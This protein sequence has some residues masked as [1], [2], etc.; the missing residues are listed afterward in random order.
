MKAN[1]YSVQHEIFTKMFYPNYY[2]GKIQNILYYGIFKTLLTYNQQSDAKIGEKNR[3][4]IFH[5]STAF[6]THFTTERSGAQLTDSQPYKCK[7]SDI[8]TLLYLHQSE[9]RH[10]PGNKLSIQTMFTNLQLN[11]N[12]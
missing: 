1:L 5:M 7:D 9:N 4:K 11:R 2:C 6:Q 10:R 8:S 12:V 3:L